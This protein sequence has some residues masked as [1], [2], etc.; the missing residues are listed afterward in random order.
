MYHTKDGDM[1]NDDFLKFVELWHEFT[2]KIENIANATAKGTYVGIEDINEEFIYF[3]HEYNNSCHCHPEDVTE[4][5]SFP[6]KYLLIEDWQTA[7]EEDKRHK[8]DLEKS[9]VEQ[10]RLQEGK[11]KA[12]EDFFRNS[13][14]L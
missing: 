4:T 8:K 12:D 11:K 7:L 1:N 2:P 14:A 13:M 10:K 9:I 3:K 6:V 5:G